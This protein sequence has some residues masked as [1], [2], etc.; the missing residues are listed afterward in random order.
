MRHPLAFAGEM[1]ADLKAS[2]ELAWRLFVRDVSAQYRQSL[3]GYFWA[4]IPPLMASLPL[5]FLNAQGV[6]TIKATPIP[7]AAYAVIGTFIWQSFVDA[8]MSPLKTAIASKQMLARI[9]FPREAI[10][11]SGLGVVAF[12][13]LI[14][15]ILLAGIFFWFHL[16]PPLTAFLFPIGILM[17]ILAGFTIGLALTPL[18]LLYNDVQQTIPVAATFLMFLTPVLYPPQESGFAGWLTHWNPLTPLVVCTRDWL[19]TGVT[20]QGPAFVL[21]AAGVVVIMLA[22]WVAYRLALPHVIARI[23]N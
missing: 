8:L 3:L 2:R 18:G 16:T 12:N 14:R 13:F 22:G 17:L 4:F 7:Y 1:V 15:T 11:L 23:G 19:T 9:N 21:V 5:V 6:V 20:A 10:L